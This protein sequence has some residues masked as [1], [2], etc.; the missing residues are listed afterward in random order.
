VGV[1]RQGTG[2]GV[3]QAA[4][5][6][7]SFCA[8]LVVGLVGTGTDWRVAFFAYSV[9]AL[10]IA[11][12]APDGPGAA[13]ADEPRRPVGPDWS[14]LTALA[15]AGGAGGAAGNG[16]AVLTVDA[17]AAAGYDE[18]LGATALAA[19]SAVTIVGRIAIGWLAGRRG[20]SGFPELGGAMAVGALGFAVLAVAASTPALLWV[21]AMVA[22]VGAWG[23]PGVMYY[24]VVRNA[25]T[26]PGTATGFVVSGVFVG[27][28]AGAPL[29]ATIADRS[30]YSAAW[31]TAAV[32]TALASVSIVAARRLALV[33]RGR[34]R[35][36]AVVGLHNQP[37][38]GQST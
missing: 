16:L 21:G 3:K 13:A 24:T 29:L 8:G 33:N 5:P 12:I 32:M 10:A 6:L 9:V 17:F 14:F 18:T 7:G 37:L 15:I 27:G 28:I 23:W 31:A 30:S 22:F 26:T 34:H 25:V 1:E 11:T 4:V 20:S 35:P 36:E 38:P 2:F 19:G